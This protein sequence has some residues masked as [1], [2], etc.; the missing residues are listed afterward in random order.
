MVVE[1]QVNFRVFRKNFKCLFYFI[2]K[3]YENLK[4]FRKA[5]KLTWISKGFWKS[6]SAN[7]PHSITP[8]LT[9]IWI[10]FIGIP[11]NS[12]N[13][14]Q[15]ELSNLDL[16]LIFENFL[17]VTSF[18]VNNT[19]TLVHS[20]AQIF[21]FFESFLRMSSFSDPFPLLQCINF[22]PSEKTSLLQRPITNWT[23]IYLKLV[24][25]F[26][27]PLPT[28]IHIFIAQYKTGGIEKWQNTR[29]HK[30]YCNTSKY[31]LYG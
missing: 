28:L 17:G 13:R 7:T 1:N 25:S 6:P 3:M 12:E 11:H 10:I 8:N 4:K 23:I 26:G 5:R 21:I 15:T 20:K 29:K 18:L 19:H 16:L 2:E 9:Y 24:F 14:W 31:D 22:G 27:T 30:H